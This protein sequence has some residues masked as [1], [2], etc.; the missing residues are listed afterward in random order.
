[1]LIFFEKQFLLPASCFFCSLNIYIQFWRQLLKP[2]LYDRV[3]EILY[4]D[5]LLLLA[6][7]CGIYQ[8]TER[9][10]FNPVYSLTLYATSA[11]QLVVEKILEDRLSGQFQPA[12]TILTVNGYSVHS[13]DELEIITDE[14]AIGSRVNVQ[15]KRQNAVLNLAVVLGPFYTNSYLIIASAV[16]LFFLSLGIFV[17]IKKPGEPA[18]RIYHWVTLAV[19]II[20]MATWGRYTVSPSGI[21]YFVRILF[22]AAYA[23]TPVL[24][25]HFVLIFPK[26]KWKKYKIL[27]KPFYLI[28]GLLFIFTSFTFILAVIPKI[29]T[30]YLALY[31]AGFDSTRWFFII[32]V[33]LAVVFIIHSLIKAVETE[34]RKKILWLMAGL[35]VGPL[36]FIFL[37]Q[38]PQVLGHAALVPEE[39]ILMITSIMPLT[40]TI[41]IVRYHIMDIEVIFNRSAVYL[42]VLLILLLLYALIIML[43]M[44]LIDSFT[45]SNSLITSAGA[46]VLLAILFEPLKK[47]VQD[48]VDRKFFRVKYNYRLAQMN[49]TEEM[50]TAVDEK[51]L[52]EFTVTKLDELMQPL[53]IA[54]YLKA[55]SAQNL[56]LIAKKNDINWENSQIEG[57]AQL[58]QTTQ[59]SL[60]A[61]RGSLEQSI[62]FVPFENMEKIPL[63]VIIS[64]LSQSGHLLGML[65]LACKRSATRYT[66]EDIDLLKTITLQFGLALERIKLQTR[67][68]LKQDETRRLEELNRMQSFFISSVS[69]D[70]Q[71]PLTS[72]RMYL[73]LLEKWENLSAE[74]KQEYLNIISGESDRLSKMIHNVLD[75]ARIERGLMSYSL[76]QINAKQ[77]IER[78]MQMMRYELNSR[79][80]KTIVDL[81][82][83]DVYIDG[84]GS[85]LERALIN[86]ISNSIKYSGKEKFISVCLAVIKKHIE[87]IV[88]DHG[89]GI[90]KNDLKKIFDMFYRGSSK[91]HLPVGGAGLG[92]SIVQHVI[93]AHQGEIKVS[94]VFGKG[95]TFVIRLPKDLRKPVP[96]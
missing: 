67:L 15:V 4:V 54:L 95:S 96:A 79:K 1:M 5:F 50:N 44:S 36:C 58:M 9:A 20:I 74:K 69:H 23:F 12:D 14:Q 42:S 25:I 24:F 2:G 34:E 19:A 73:D 76:H 40:F 29:S 8:L 10:G 30:T 59:Q 57:F 49:F 13:L 7:C 86:L 45:T 64:I 21:G 93:N 46:I 72:I 55:E 3:R 48:V 33:L 27:L 16:A 68:V 28:A 52:A 31:L 47:R 11:R 78:V 75:S 66:S 71:T 83:E 65:T 63:A 22:S 70:L 53:A 77:L 43:V 61:K 89:L 37:W 91:D 26:I 32:S 17:L 88:S 85:A 51:T 80:F 38:L 6:G 62:D 18:A 84:D 35:I 94:S 81:P 39:V 90:D 92:L 56:N 82:E 87:I 60:L 41:S